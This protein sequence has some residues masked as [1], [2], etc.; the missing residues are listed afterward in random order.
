[1][2]ESH[3]KGVANHPDPESCVASRE[4]AIEALTGAHAGWVLSC[5]IIL[6]EERL[7]AGV[8]I[9][10]RGVAKITCLN[11]CGQRVTVAL[12][13]PGPIPEFPSLPVRRWHVRFETHSDCRLDSLGWNQF[14]VIYQGGT[15]IC[16]KKISRKQSDAMGSVLRRGPRS[17][18]TSGDYASSIMFKL[19]THRVTW[20]PLASLP[21]PQDD[22]PR[23]IARIEGKKI[24]RRWGALS[25][26]GT[27]IHAQCVPRRCRGENGR[28]PSGHALP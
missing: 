10:L 7:A 8:H 12:L 25:Q 18:R 1:M 5:E 9:L 23:S 6:P 20:Y 15:S 2:K 11:G 3:R 28:L 19:R 22:G 21:Q 26:P 13:A 14:D 4:A 24:N 17:S 27:T 16:F